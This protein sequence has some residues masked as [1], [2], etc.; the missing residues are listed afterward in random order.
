MQHGGYL[1]NDRILR[2][3]KTVLACST[4]GSD[5]VLYG[6]LHSHKQ[7]LQKIL[8]RTDFLLTER[9]ID[10]QIAQELGFV[11][12]TVSPSYVT[13]GTED[14][15]VQNTLP[16]RRKKIVIKGYQD[17][18]GRALNVLQAL[19]LIPN[20]ILDFELVVIAGS[21]SV[22]VY[23]EYLRSA[24]NINIVC[25]PKMDR[26]EIMNLFA[27]SRLYIGLGISDGI[28]NTMIESM[29]N[30]AFPIQSENSC[31]SKF[32]DNGVSGYVVDPW[33]I[34]KIASLIEVS[35]RDNKLVDGAVE[36]NLSTLREKYSRSRGIK[37]LDSLYEGILNGR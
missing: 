28:S 18:H 1:L 26:S 33:D 24:K 23:A 9:D 27:E 3:E 2:N 16:S 34:P 22:R 5:L 20:A 15:K 37:I 8:A 25:A 4:W 6:K 12:K 29:Q 13:V 17:N 14:L 10:V 21:E 32:I 30:G 11:G 31:A 7:K 36:L 35:L 19:T